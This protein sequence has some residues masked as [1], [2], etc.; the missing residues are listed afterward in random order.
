MRLSFQILV[1]LKKLNLFMLTAKLL[2]QNIQ[3]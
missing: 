1:A 3:G 2:T